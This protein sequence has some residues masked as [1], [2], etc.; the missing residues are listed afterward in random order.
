M[1]DQYL[2]TLIK[3]KRNSGFRYVETDLMNKTKIENISV[4]FGMLK[5][6]IIESDGGKPCDTYFNIEQIK[7]IQFSK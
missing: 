6:S 3:D 1:N 5:C 7:V 4:E 2:K